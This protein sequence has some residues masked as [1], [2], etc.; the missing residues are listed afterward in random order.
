M[1]RRRPPPPWAALQVLLFALVAIGITDRATGSPPRGGLVN[2]DIRDMS[3]PLV[4]Q[5]R[6]AGVPPACQSVPNAFHS[7]PN[8]SAKVF[9]EWS[10][11]FQ[12]VPES[13]LHREA[14]H[15][16]SK[17]FQS[18]PAKVF[19]PKCS[20]ALRALL[21]PPLNSSHLRWAGPARWRAP[22]R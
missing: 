13:F 22:F 9:L 14:G 19:R 15:G 8:R 17:A 1:A 2:H 7:V 16:C 18:V 20:G 3:L 10:K 5:N 6:A 11:V 12:I 4:G 21:R